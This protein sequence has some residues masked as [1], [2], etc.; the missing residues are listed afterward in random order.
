MYI[1]DD[2]LDEGSK[3]Q[4]RMFISFPQ[5]VMYIVHTMR[6]IFLKKKFCIIAADGG[7]LHSKGA[8]Y[9][10]CYASHSWRYKATYDV[11]AALWCHMVSGCLGDVSNEDLA[12]VENNQFTN[13]IK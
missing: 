1:L 2:I 3:F 8:A 4:N 9:S 10:G 7:T 13:L 5:F 6:Y 12:I 11:T